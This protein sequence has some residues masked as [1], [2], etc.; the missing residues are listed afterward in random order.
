MTNAL[1]HLALHEQLRLTGGGCP[2]CRPGMRCACGSCASCRSGRAGC[3][4]GGGCGRCRGAA[5]FVA[6][7]FPARTGRRATR[8]R[9]RGAGFENLNDDASDAFA[10]LET[11]G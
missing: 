5:Q 11:L 4:C 9:G 7:G 10:R 6:T 8:G 1:D 2:Q 3:G